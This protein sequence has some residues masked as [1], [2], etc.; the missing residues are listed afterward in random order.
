MPNI[1]LKPCP[2]CG[3]EAMVMRAKSRKFFRVYDEYPYIQCTCCGS[4]TLLK[5]TEHEA[6][7]VWNRR[8]ND[9]VD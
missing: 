3:G 2:F 1:N 8:V 5:Y 6:A 9:E 4:H 7:A